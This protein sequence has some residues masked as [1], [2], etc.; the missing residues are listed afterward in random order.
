VEVVEY[1]NYDQSRSFAALNAAIDTP[2]EQQPKVYCIWPM[3]VESKRLAGKLFEI[4]R[5][6][7]VQINQLPDDWELEHLL[8]YAGP[9]DAERAGN[10][11]IM[12]VDAM[13]ERGVANAKVIALGYPASYGGY[14]LS[15]EAFRSSIDSSINIVKE[16]PLAR[17]DLRQS[18][19]MEI[20]NL[21]DNNVEFNGVYAM[22]DDI[23]LGA[24][25][26][27]ND[28]GKV[29]VKGENDGPDAVTLVGTVCN[30]AREL[31]ENG[32]QYGTTVQAPFLEAALAF[33]QA[34]EY[35]ETGKLNQTIR[36]TPNPIA[37]GES[38]NG[39]IVEFLGKAYAADSLCTWNVYHERI[40]GL[41]DTADT[42]NVCSWVDCIFI[43]E[44]LFIAGYVMVAINYLLIVVCSIRLFIHRKKKIILLAQPFFLA[45]ILLGSAVDTTSIIFM[46]RDSRDY[47]RAELDA[48][49]AAFV[50]LLT[51]GQM[52]T[53][54]TLVA[55]IYRVKKVTAQLRPG[56]S[57]IAKKTKVTTKDVA[58]F[59]IGG[60][61]V[62]I[63]ILGV[64]FGTD[65]FRWST[66]P[67][68][69]DFNG[70]I[71]QAVGQ[72]SSN[73]TNSWV[74][75]MIIVILHLLLLVYAN[76]LAYQTRAFHKISDSK[77]AAVCVFNSIQLL[78]I[79]TII[80]AMSG[81]NVA[82]A[83]I[84]KACYAFL[85]NFG[86]IALMILPKLYK[87]LLNKGDDVNL[88]VSGIR[89]TRRSQPP[90]Q[91]GNISGLGDVSHI[92][93]AS[94]YNDRVSFADASVTEST[95]R[96]PTEPD[97][98]EGSEEG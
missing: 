29:Y 1:G 13:K 89:N 21:I 44:G 84:I 30:G 41:M 9:K 45:L 93:R 78:L 69:Q 68:S 20:V 79:A 19:Y 95:S 43:P 32:K 62:D 48:G 66:T 35:I 12:M 55:K 26:A 60:L 15:I 82:I 18:A 74:Y 52:L 90:T 87:C 58:F 65:P 67:T 56:A 50:W 39:M 10:A 5:V 22:D 8:G 25:E 6:P 92:D 49:C 17:P 72:C 96:R 54:A 53:T 51:L 71:L 2:T 40:N 42:E 59:I 88:A 77:M 64:W 16:T 7:I 94:L 63:I 81:N 3:D 70:L 98:A 73:G 83:Y 76:V 91:Q 97:I 24:Y 4:H 86:V 46:S 34:M 33:E 85:N 11:G 57:N 47:T 27:L 75:P 80:V 37:T 61:I 36:F 38:W 23:L 31:L 14:P 28:Q